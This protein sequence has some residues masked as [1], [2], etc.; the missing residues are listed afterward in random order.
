MNHII[1]REAGEAD[2]PTIV[3]ITQAAFREYEGLLDPPSSVR[4]ETPERVRAKLAEGVGLLAALADRAV[5][6][7]YYTP[8]DG[9]VYMGRLAVLPEFRRHGVGLA[10]VGEVER[11]VREL[12]LPAVRIGVRVAL[13]HLRGFYERMGYCVIAEHSHPGYSTTTFVTMEKRLAARSD[14]SFA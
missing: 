6:S 1:I 10:L 2:I 13:P 9:H 11:R 8:R 4:D 12:G 7:V 14:S 3:A 5:G